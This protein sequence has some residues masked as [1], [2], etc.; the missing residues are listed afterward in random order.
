MPGDEKPVLFRP[1]L[2][3][4]CQCW[5]PFEDTH[6]TGPLCLWKAVRKT[7][8]PC[9]MNHLDIS[10]LQSLYQCFF[11][12]NTFTSVHFSPSLV[13]QATF[14]SCQDLPVK[15]WQVLLYSLFPLPA[16]PHAAKSTIFSKPMA[17]LSWLPLLFG[18]KQWSLK[19]P[20]PIPPI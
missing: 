9:C 5:V 19:W 17:T 2:D 8:G 1:L 20:L 13:G 15:S 16:I 3:H 18:S 6:D 12:L 10:P 4:T 11:P 7:C 14:L